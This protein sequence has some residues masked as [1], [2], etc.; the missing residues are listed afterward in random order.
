MAGNE[1]S[2]R[3]ARTENPAGLAT[4]GGHYS[5]VA[6]A[7]GLVFV[8]GQLPI[9]ANGRKLTDASFETQAEQVLANIEAALEGAGSSIGQ[10]VQV[11]VYIADVEHWASFNQIYARWAGDARPARAVVPTGPLHFG[12][13]IEIEATAMV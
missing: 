3:R 11:R 1:Q 9:D 12:F 7:N 10:L 8:S 4:P 13:K 6:I 5:H 2:A